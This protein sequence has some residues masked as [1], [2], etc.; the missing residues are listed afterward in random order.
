MQIPTAEGNDCPQCL[1]RGQKQ[2]APA[3]FKD[4]HLEKNNVSTPLLDVDTLNKLVP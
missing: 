4:S 2:R 3:S 1:S